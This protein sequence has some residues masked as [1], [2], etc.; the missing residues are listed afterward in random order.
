MF[1]VNSSRGSYGH[2]YADDNDSSEDWKIRGLADII[3]SGEYDD[4]NYQSISKDLLLMSL[5]LYQNLVKLGAV[6]GAMK[7]IVLEIAN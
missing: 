2:D 6:K 1:L 4:I 5:I 7:T 3:S